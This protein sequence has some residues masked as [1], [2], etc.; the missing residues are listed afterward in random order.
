MLQLRQGFGRLIRGHADR[1]VVAILD[2]RLRTRPYGRAFLAALPRCPVA[3]ESG[4]GC[5]VLRRDASPFPLEWRAAWRRRSPGRRRLRPPG[6]GA[7]AAQGRHAEGRPDDPGSG[8]GCSSTPSAAAG[9]IGLDRGRRRRRAGRRRRQRR[10][11]TS[12]SPPLMTAAGC[13][14][15]TVK[16]L[17]PGGAAHARQQPHR[18]SSRG[19]RPAVE[20]PALSAVGGLGLLHR[21]G[22]PADGRA[23]RGARR[24]DPLVGPEGPGSRRWRSCTRSTTSTRPACSAR[25]TRTLGSK[26]AITAWTGN[27]RTTSRT[28]TSAG[29][30]RGL[31]ALHVCRPRRRSRRSATRTAATAPRASRSQQRQAGHGPARPA[32]RRLRLSPAGVAEPVDAAGLKPAAFGRGGSTP[33]PGTLARSPAPLRGARTTRAF[34]G[35]DCR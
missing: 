25:R 10:R 15:K 11:T 19:T 1:G 23:Q 14:F 22:Q 16:A 27:P 5:G 6:P 3:E 29:P 17:R 35:S 13:T 30:H 18:R 9:I 7:E 8:T 33:S 32:V 20:R 24:R 4:G 28:A 26:V 12:R 34:A 21:A 2:P 31:P